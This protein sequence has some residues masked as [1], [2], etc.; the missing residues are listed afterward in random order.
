MTK[1]EIGQIS[2]IGRSAFVICFLAGT[3]IRRATHHPAGIIAGGVV[4]IY[5][6][7]AI[8]VVQQWEKVAVLRLGRYVGLRGPGIFL[9]IPVVDT[10]S[11]YVDQRI[12]VSNV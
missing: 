3:G 6:M 7:F 12:R 11:A 5:C 10:L 4:G 2:G 9:I 1:I 8:K